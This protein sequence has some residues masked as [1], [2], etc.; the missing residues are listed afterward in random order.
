M[1]IPA[2]GNLVA[3]GIKTGLAEKQVVAAVIVVQGGIITLSMRSGVRFKVVSAA[4]RY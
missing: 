3:M 4:P 1:G 2:E